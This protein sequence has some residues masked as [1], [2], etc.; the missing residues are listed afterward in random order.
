MAQITL[1]AEACLAA[2]H[3][4]ITDYLLAER[5]AHPSLREV[6]ARLPDY[7][8]GHGLAASAPGIAA[9]ARLERTHRALF[10]GPDALPLTMDDLRA[11]APED[12]VALAVRLIPCHALLAHQP[13]WSTVWE[14]PRAGDS[15][16]PDASAE[17]VLAWR[18]GFTVR[19]RAVGDDGER[20]MLARAARG[21][22]LGQLCETFVAASP[23]YEEAAL[24]GQ[25][26][27]VLA[28]WVDDGVLTRA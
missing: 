19:H 28:R 18:Q 23:S 12:F 8:A 17:V 26:F 9:L 22:T 10:D 24:A 4:L 15:V 20:A 16:E 2:F 14:G 11:L 1:G 6:G 21:A 5:P 25:A 27:A 7:L 13:A 3:D